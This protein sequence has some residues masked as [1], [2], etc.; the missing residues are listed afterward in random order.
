MMNP[1]GTLIRILLVCRS[2]VHVNRQL[3]DILLCHNKNITVTVLRVTFLQGAIPEGVIST[4]SVGIWRVLFDACSVS[5]AHTQTLFPC[6]SAQS[7]R[8]LVP[9]QNGFRYQLLKPCLNAC[10]KCNCLFFHKESA[11]LSP[12]ECPTSYIIAVKSM[13]ATTWSCFNLHRQKLLLIKSQSNHTNK[14]Y[15]HWFSR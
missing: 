3:T 9:P 12:H 14:L 8:K 1:V 13:T 2:I 7:S 4:S 5:D 11:L 10:T 15:F 6:L